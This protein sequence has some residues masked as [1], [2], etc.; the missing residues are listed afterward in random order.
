MGHRAAAAGSDSG[1]EAAAGAIAKHRMPRHQ[2]AAAAL[3]TKRGIALPAFTADHTALD[4]NGVARPDA[5]PIPLNDAVLHETA[6]ADDDTCLA[7]AE[8]HGGDRVPR[9]CAEHERGVPRAQKAADFDF[10]DVLFSGYDPTTQAHDTESWDTSSSA[11]ASHVVPLGW[12]IRTTNC[13]FVRLKTFVSRYTPEMGERISGV[14]AAQITDIGTGSG[15]G[16]TGHVP[17]RG[18]SRLAERGIVEPGIIAHI[19]RA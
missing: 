16:A 9:R 15:S 18:F 10:K 4:L 8:P 5:E 12:T 11:R 19:G 1:V 6:G 17:L 2:H 7:V 3:Q 14:P 13:V